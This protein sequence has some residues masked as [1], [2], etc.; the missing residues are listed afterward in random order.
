[1]IE[2][3]IYFCFFFHWFPGSTHVSVK[4]NNLKPKTPMN[5][6]P[7][8]HTAWGFFV[9]LLYGATTFWLLTICV[10]SDLYIGACSDTKDCYPGSCATSGNTCDCPP[11]FSGVNCQTCKWQT[12]PCGSQSVTCI[13]QTAGW[14]LINCFSIHQK[15]NFYTLAKNNNVSNFLI[16]QT[17]LSS[18]M[19]SQSVPLLAILA[20]S[21]TLTCLSLI[22]STL[23]P[24]LVIFTSETSVK[25]VIF[26]LFLQQQLL[27]IHLSP[28]NL[29]TTIHYTLHIQLNLWNVCCLSYC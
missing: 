26:F 10:F 6:T 24:N 12:I 21:L 19:S 13:W 28:V 1:M 27:Q 17:Y 29:T 14:I 7:K 20:S 11:G 25:S 15:L 9:A 3:F 18:M 5:F 22:K 23:Y 8:F 4:D 16:W 2:I